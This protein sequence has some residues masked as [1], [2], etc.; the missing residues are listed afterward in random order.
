MRYELKEKDLQRFMLKIQKT[1]TCWIYHG[2]KCLK[3]YGLF[4]FK[5]SN[6]RAHRLSYSI[7]NGDI[8][9]G[10]YVLHSC[11]VRDC[12]NPDH[13]SV[14]TQSD[15][16]RQAAERGRLWKQNIYSSG[17]CPNGHIMDS[18]NQIM[19]AGNITCKACLRMKQKRAN[20]KAWQKRKDYHRLFVASGKLF[21]EI[22]KEWKYYYVLD[23]K[24]F[25]TLT[26]AAKNFNVTPAAMSYRYTK[27][28]I[29]KIDIDELFK[30]SQ[31]LFDHHFPSLQ[32]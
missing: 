22:E 32:N 30:A 26:V 2:N 15:N 24:L 4:R 8:P 19:R 27:G 31:A 6:I 10:L 3:G 20:A 13:L 28:Q 18:E 16:M 7:H 1:D 12:V 23:G 14:G 29:F 11:D 9:D 25:E 17:K 5:A 21:T